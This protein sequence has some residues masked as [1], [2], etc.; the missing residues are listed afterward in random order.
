MPKPRVYVIGALVVLISVLFI[1][2][3]RGT[4]PFQALQPGED[5]VLDCTN[6]PSCRQLF[7]SEGASEQEIDSLMEIVDCKDNVCVM[8][9]TTAE[10][11]ESV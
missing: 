5:V 7:K 8:R 6:E 2:G 3:L 4:G 10:E 9:M 1:F 11:E